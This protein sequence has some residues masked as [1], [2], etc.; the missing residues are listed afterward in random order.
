MSTNHYNS[1][2]KLLLTGEYFVLDGA[3]SLALPCQFGQDLIVDFH[4]KPTLIW[5]SF[6]VDK[7]LWLEV[8][9]TLPDLKI[10]SS[11]YSSNNEKNNENYE[12]KLQDMLLKAKSLNKLFLTDNSGI[13]VKTH[14]SFNRHWGLGTSSTLIHNIAQWA[15]VC[16]YK[17]LELTFG[18]SGYDIACAKHSSPIHYTIQGENRIVT[19]VDFTPYFYEQLYFVYLNKKQNS[20]EGIQLYRKA[21]KSS[22]DINEISKLTDSITTC[23]SLDAFEE[24]ITEHEH[25]ISKTIQLPTVQ[26]SIFKDYFGKIKS[27]GAWGGDFILATGNKDTPNYFKNKGFSTIIPYNEMVIS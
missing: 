5:R 14:L 16:P 12:L 17:L 25:I 23:N 20:R 21:Q 22:T 10:I 11:S 27:L 1:N 7:S 2:G 3:K 6:D 19:K 4:S 26:K 15:N 9:L 8:I 18:G 13:R 24:L